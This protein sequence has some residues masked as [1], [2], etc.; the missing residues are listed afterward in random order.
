VHALPCACRRLGFLCPTSQRSANSTIT[1]LTARNLILL[2][3][4]V[5]KFD[6]SG[7]GRRSKHDIFQSRYLIRGILSPHNEK[8]ES[9]TQCSEYCRTLLSIFDYTQQAIQHISHTSTNFQKKISLE[10]ILFVTLQSFRHAAHLTHFIH[11]RYRAS[12]VDRKSATC[13][14]NQAYL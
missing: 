9:P 13:L 6:G 7:V 14:M 11:L 4:S 12:L 3:N 10:E 8:K 1:S 5:L 2:E